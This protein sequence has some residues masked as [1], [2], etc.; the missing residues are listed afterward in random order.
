MC[1]AAPPLALV[2]DVVAG[3]ALSGD[4]GDME[5]SSTDPRAPSLQL[6]IES[7]THCHKV[8]TVGPRKRQ[9]DPITVDHDWLMM[10]MPGF[11]AGFGP[12]KAAMGVATIT[13][14]QSGLWSR[15]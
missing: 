15:A 6:V 10:A 12:H 8:A 2:I 4:V 14:S 1:A 11:H 5:R 9:L 3:G 13:I 7:I